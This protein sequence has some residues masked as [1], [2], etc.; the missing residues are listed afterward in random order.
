[1]LKWAKWQAQLG[2]T[3]LAP[4]FFNFNRDTLASGKTRMA[5]KTSESAAMWCLASN[6]KHM[7]LA[8]QS[9]LCCK[10]MGSNAPI[11]APCSCNF[12]HDTLASG[13]TRMA[14]KISKFITAW[15]L[16]SNSKNMPLAMKGQINKEK[17]QTFPNTTQTWIALG[18]LVATYNFAASLFSTAQFPF[19]TNLDPASW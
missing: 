18:K 8:M 15:W 14:S 3:I 10:D 5:P 12:N 2:R 17:S 4:C 9:H 19:R 1:M 16:A 7:P 13:K 6:W 11:L